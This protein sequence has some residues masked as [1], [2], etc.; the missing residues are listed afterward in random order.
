M[1]KLKI[2]QTVDEPIEGVDPLAT[3]LDA[4]A[5]QVRLDDLSYLLPYMGQLARDSLF[6]K[7]RRE[8]S[9]HLVMHA[10]LLTEQLGCVAEGI[11]LASTEG[12]L[13]AFSN[14]DGRVQLMFLVAN[15]SKIAAGLLYAHEYTR[16]ADASE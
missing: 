1:A 12:D 9:D 6:E 5:E 10:R 8:L 11:G 14:N 3:A 2:A 13:G 4:R 7:Q 16:V 15:V